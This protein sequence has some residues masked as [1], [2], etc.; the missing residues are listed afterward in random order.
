[1]STNILIGEHRGGFF[2]A[3]P[4]GVLGGKDVVARFL[5]DEAGQ[6][7]RTQQEVLGIVRNYLDIEPTS[8]TNAMVSLG[9]DDF[10]VFEVIQGGV[11]VLF[12]NVKYSTLVSE[13]V[14]FDDDHLKSLEQ[15]VGEIAHQEMIDGE[16][17][18]S[19]DF[20]VAEKEDVVVS[21]WINNQ[22][23]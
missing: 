15:M 22:G 2:L 23:E 9:S 20:T 17:S 16:P 5:V 6:K 3:F 10:D 13:Y 1:M 19:F 7:N 18:G 21:W 14:L 4:E 11:H 12:H 8:Y